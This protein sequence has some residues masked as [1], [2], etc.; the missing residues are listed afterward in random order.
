M[1]KIKKRIDTGKLKVKYVLGIHST[2]NGYPT[3]EDILYEMIRDYC[4]KV[5]KEIKFTDTS[6]Q[7]R[8]SL[9]KERT[10]ELIQDLEVKGFLE[11]VND[12]AAYT[13]Y[14]V[15]RNPYE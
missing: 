13:T 10:S 11:A 14:Q 1:M 9:T 15:I 5:A 4:A 12:N 3:S 2:L 8:Y 6:L 7:K